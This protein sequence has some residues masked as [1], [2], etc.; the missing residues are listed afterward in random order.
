MFSIYIND[1]FLFRDNGC[2]S[3]YADDATLYLI[4]ENH[5][6]NRNILNKNFLI[7]ANLS[8]SIITCF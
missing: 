6:T 3:N 2:L 8:I 1:I 5:N 4:G 7:S